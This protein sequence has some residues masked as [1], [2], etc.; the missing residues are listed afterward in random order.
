MLLPSNVTVFKVY[1][2]ISNT[3]GCLSSRHEI[4]KPRSLRITGK[5][6]KFHTEM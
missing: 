4:D 2:S 5:K 6:I 1:L 3:L